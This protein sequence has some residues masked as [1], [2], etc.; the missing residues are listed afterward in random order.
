MNRSKD[1]RIFKSIS[2]WLKKYMLL[3]SNTKEKV[4]NAEIFL[5]KHPMLKKLNNRNPK[6][7]LSSHLLKHLLTDIWVIHSMEVYNRIHS[8]NRNKRTLSTKDSNIIAIRKC[9]PLKYSLL[10]SN[11]QNHQQFRRRYKSNK[12]RKEYKIC[13]GRI[14]FLRTN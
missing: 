14:I 2:K 12:E 9:R 8:L 3:V 5:F 6:T 10:T 4:K 13:S 7:F 11:I 1:N